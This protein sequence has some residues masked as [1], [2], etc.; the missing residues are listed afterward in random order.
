MSII[1]EEAD[2]LLPEDQFEFQTSFA[3]LFGGGLRW[4]VGERMVVRA[5][6]SMMLWRLRS[7]P[8]FGLPERELEGVDETEWV[9]GPSFSIGT[10]I[11]F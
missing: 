11:R 8:G 2:L 9:S 1:P 5:D 4:F 7:P 6:L 10:G 3:G